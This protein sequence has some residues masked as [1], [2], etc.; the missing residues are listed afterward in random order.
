ML[1]GNDTV[2]CF[3]SETPST[4]VEIAFVLSCNLAAGRVLLYISTVSIQCNSSYGQS[5][6]T[7]STALTGK[8][9]LL[10]N[11]TVRYSSDIEESTFNHANKNW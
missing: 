10:V 1:T 3:S 8:C 5:G 6:A 9:S 4:I 11:L 7:W 2:C